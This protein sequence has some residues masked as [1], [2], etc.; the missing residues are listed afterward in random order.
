[1]DGKGT[2][3]PRILKTPGLDE[4][5]HLQDKVAAALADLRHRH[6]ALSLETLEANAVFYWRRSFRTRA[7]WKEPGEAID[8]G[9][10][11]SRRT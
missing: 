7:G 9:L 8:R 5:L 4:N 3:P 2:A 1:L 10:H 11:D 6:G